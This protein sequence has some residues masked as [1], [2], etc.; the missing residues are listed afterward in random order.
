[1]GNRRTFEDWLQELKEI[2]QD[3]FEME[4]D[5]LP[6]FDRSDARNYYKERSAPSLYFKECLSEHAE[7]GER[8]AEIL[9][10]V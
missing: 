1:M 2:V 10:E 7:G 6:E 3:Q 4:L 8:L 5:Q 9:R